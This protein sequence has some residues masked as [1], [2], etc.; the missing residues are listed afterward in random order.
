M[1][2]APNQGFRCDSAEHALVPHACVVHATLCMRMCNTVYCIGGDVWT[3]AV[4]RNRI[5]NYCNEG[6]WE[7]PL[8]N[9]EAPLHSPARSRHPTACR[10]SH[11]RALP[12]P[13]RTA[14]SR[15]ANTQTLAP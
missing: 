3:V 5:Q 10:G 1:C 7:V 6:G 14:G 8:P 12:H 9:W 11:R 13:R 15:I 2:P 4:T